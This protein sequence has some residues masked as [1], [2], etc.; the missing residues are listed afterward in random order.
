MDFVNFIVINK[1]NFFAKLIQNSVTFDKP[2]VLDFGK[3]L[4]F[5]L[6]I[7]LVRKYLRIFDFKMQILWLKVIVKKSAP[8]YRDAFVN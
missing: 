3:M 8:F 6:K 1:F 7:L 5:Y 4:N 2:I